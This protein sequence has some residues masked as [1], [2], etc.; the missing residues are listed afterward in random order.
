MKIAR[1]LLIAL[2]ALLALSVAGSALAV[3]DVDV[4]WLTSSD[5]GASV[6]GVVS[7]QHIF[8]PGPGLTLDDVDSVESVWLYVGVVQ[9]TCGSAGGC[10]EDLLFDA[11]QVETAALDLTGVSWSAGRA[12]VQI[13]WGD[14]TAEADLE[15]NAGILNVTV[16]ASD[17]ALAVL[18]SKMVT[19]YT[20]GSTGGTGSG[21]VNAI[22]EPSAALVFAFGALIM[23]RGARRNLG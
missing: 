11:D 3:T 13:L 20:W 2:T 7:Y 1:N 6:D 9:W 19:T 4:D 12:T 14:I 22:P 17:G 10:A 18:G 21:G 23:T 8:D 5:I 16:T 15:A